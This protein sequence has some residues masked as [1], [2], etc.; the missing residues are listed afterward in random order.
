MVYLS[1]TNN[2]YIYVQYGIRP[3]QYV[4]VCILRIY[5]YI[6]TYRYELHEEVRILNVFYVH[7]HTIGISTIRTND[8]KT[9]HIYVQIRTN[10]RT[11]KYVQ[12]YV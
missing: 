12:L 6:H 1:R 11:Q 7:I 8:T 10:I 2:M 3:D 5:M 4:F 9:K